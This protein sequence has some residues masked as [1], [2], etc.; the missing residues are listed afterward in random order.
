MKVSIY[1]SLI[2][3]R[4]IFDESSILRHFRLLHANAASC[5]NCGCFMFRLRYI[6]SQQWS[7]HVSWIIS[8][9]FIWNKVDT[10]EYI[11]RLVLFDAKRKLVNISI[12][13]ACALI[14]KKNKVASI[15]TLITSAPIVP[16]AIF[17]TTTGLSSLRSLLLL[18]VSHAMSTL[19]CH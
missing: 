2:I 9:L 12:K 15:G 14:V 11:D 19:C 13:F 8:D 6:N 5:C 7:A 16:S 4:V 10:F 3:H 1:L 18:G 17:L